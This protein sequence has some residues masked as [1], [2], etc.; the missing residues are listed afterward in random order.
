MLY[1]ICLFKSNSV[2]FKAKPEPSIKYIAIVKN[3]AEELL[4]LFYAHSTF[5]LNIITQCRGFHNGRIILPD[6]RTRIIIIDN[7]REE[8]VC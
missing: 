2:I 8:I 6:G 3:K 1:F 7:Q 4:L 5:S